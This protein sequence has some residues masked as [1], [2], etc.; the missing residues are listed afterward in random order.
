V[1]ARPNPALTP[2]EV[3]A[4]RVARHV[5]LRTKMAVY[6]SYGIGLLARLRYVIDHLIPL[7]LNGTNSVRNLWPQPRA[8]AKAKDRE[9]GTLAAAVADGSLTLGAAQLRMLNDWGA[10]NRLEKR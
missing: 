6:R 2:G 3:G 4:Q 9:E 7:E 1:N 5:T 10:S 8:Q